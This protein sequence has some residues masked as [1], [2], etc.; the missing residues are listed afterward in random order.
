MRIFSYRNKQRLKRTLIA[1]L[2]IAVALA[3]SAL[4]YMIYLGRFMVYTTDGAYLQ[5][6][7]EDIVQ[8]TTSD[9]TVSVAVPD[10]SSFEIG[11]SV[12]RPDTLQTT[13]QP[14]D[15]QPDA[16]LCADG[17]YAD[18]AALLNASQSHIALSALLDEAEGTVS[19]MLD[20]KS[21]F[22]N[23]Y[24]STGL[25]GAPIATSADIAAVDALI[26]SVAS[27]PDVYLIARIPAFRDFNY[28]L[29]HTN[30]ALALSSGALW[31]DGSGCYWLDP[32]NRAVLTRLVDICEE[33]YMLGFEEVIF[34]NFCFPNGE[35]IVYEADRAETIREAAETVV[36]DSPIPV[37]FCFTE[38]DAQYAAVTSGLH[39]CLEAK[40]GSDIARALALVADALTG[41]SEQVIFLSN[42]HDT[43]FDEYIQLRQIIED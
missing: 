20:L 14:D 19:V 22:G 16:I 21:E 25:T 3:V 41:E 27:R 2:V 1:V 26:A 38:T 17:Y 6:P 12:E 30:Q 33:L 4:S 7:G 42:S 11:E 15:T 32:A 28:A 24:Y 43:R 36:N 10:G 31:A 37:S 39:L 34:E 13:T 29:E 8:D 18:S 23:F 35:S 9:D 40:T 5:L